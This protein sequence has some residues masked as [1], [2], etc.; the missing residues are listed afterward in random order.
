MNLEGEMTSEIPY[1]DLPE[2]ALAP[3]FEVSD[4]DLVGN[5]PNS[6]NPIE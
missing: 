6:E 2:D 4:D 1:V 5:L 3:A